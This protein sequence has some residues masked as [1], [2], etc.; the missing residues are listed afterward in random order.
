MP[1]ILIKL[2]VIIL[3]G[4]LAGFI[5]GRITESKNGFLMSVISGVV[6]D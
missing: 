2:I 4:T 5:A 1:V 6:G 3:P